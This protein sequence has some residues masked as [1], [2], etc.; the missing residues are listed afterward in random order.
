MVLQYINAHCRC[1]SSDESIWPFPVKD[2]DVSKKILC[3][4]SDRISFAFPCLNIEEFY[5]GYSS[6]SMAKASLLRSLLMHGIMNILPSQG[7]DPI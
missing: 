1:K 5:G 6:L 7:W 4:S 3:V 2:E